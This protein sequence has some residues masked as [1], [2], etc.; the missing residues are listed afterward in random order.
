MNNRKIRHSKPIK[1]VLNLL[2]D[3]RA[4][5]VVLSTLIITAGVIAAGIAVLYWA[6]GWGNV[7]DQQY[8]TITSDSMSAM[9]EQLGFEYTTYSSSL[10]QLTVYLIN[11]GTSNNLTIA[12]VYLW[13]STFVPISGKFTLS[14][15]YYTATGKQIP[16]STGG[17]GIGKEGYFNLS[18]LS[19]SSGTY[20]NLRVVTGRGSDFDEAF[21]T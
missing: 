10:G 3:K 16:T 9:G 7:A 14:P 1:L 5:S 12:R 18:G 4:I 8:S 15:L 13:S 20:Y 2:F 17:L 21:S 6:Y 19:L 11:C